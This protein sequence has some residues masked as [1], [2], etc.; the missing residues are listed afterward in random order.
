MPD[1]AVAVFA[2]A[3]VPGY[4]KTRLISRLGPDGAA[5]FAAR[6][7]EH[8]VR[9]AVSA[10]I[11]PVTLWCAPD[12][13]HPL[14]Q[15]LGRRG[16]SLAVQ[17]AGDLGFRM[18]AALQ[19]TTG[20]LVLIGTDCPELRAGDLRD[21][22]GALAAG[23]DAVI[24]PSEDGGYGL[25]AAGRP[26][27]CLFRDIPWSTGEVAAATRARAAEN[28]VTLA[29]LRTILDVDTPEDWDRLTLVEP[30]LARGPGHAIAS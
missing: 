30:E 18:L 16:P 7:I 10:G 21:A 14:F 22:A 26:I 29:E 27:P 12:A 19:A 2:K 15:A 23:A 9:T 28:G 6:L 1:A 24:A 5:A 8:T 20:A 25:I 3:P 13:G 17:P 4:A 11:G